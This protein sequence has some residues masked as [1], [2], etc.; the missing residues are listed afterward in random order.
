MLA[1]LPFTAVKSMDG[2]Y[3]NIRIPLESLPEALRHEPGRFN[4]RLG[5]EIQPTPA[6]G[7]HWPRYVLKFLKRA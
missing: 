4:L 6:R 2:R 5:D 1:T 3:L 7:P